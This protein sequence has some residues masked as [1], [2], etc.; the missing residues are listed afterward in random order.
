MV[1]PD[2]SLTSCSTVMNHTF[3]RPETSSLLYHKLFQR[4]LIGVFLLVA[5]LLIRNKIDNVG[6][7]FRFLLQVGKLFSLLMCSKIELIF[8]NLRILHRTN[9]ILTLIFFNN[10]VA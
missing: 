7:L 8:R 1:L 5:L 2:E 9:S 4:I 6:N 10:N 3:A